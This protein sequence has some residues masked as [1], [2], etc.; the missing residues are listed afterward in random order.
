METIKQGLERFLRYNPNSGISEV[1]FNVRGY[2]WDSWKLV[3]KC[4]ECCVED[5]SILT[6]KVNSTNGTQTIVY[7]LKECDMG[8]DNECAKTK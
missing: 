5:G 4:I 1:I 6:K 8:F 3:K 2:G 7:R